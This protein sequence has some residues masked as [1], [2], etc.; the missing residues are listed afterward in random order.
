[1]AQTR[2]SP[3]LSRGFSLTIAFLLPGLISLFGVATVEPTVQTWFRG[4]QS[5]PTLA[6][7]L[8]V[9][10]AALAMNVVVTAVRWFFFEFISMPGFGSIIPVSPTFDQKK[11]KRL[12]AQYIDLRHQFYYHYLAYA[13]S[14]VAILLAVIAWR[15][16]GDVA[17]P[18]TVTMAVFV[19]A[20]I[21]SIIL[22]LAARDA[23]K[24]YDKQTESLIGLATS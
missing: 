6:G 8:F 20:T 18:H 9:L 2:P 13:N 5:G 12:E 10:L 21:T 7:L 11:R 17:P 1:M 22:T 24:R 16:I 4:A 3:T 14:S 23:I 19:V 15:F